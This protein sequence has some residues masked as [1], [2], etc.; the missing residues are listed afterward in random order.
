VCLSGKE[1]REEEKGASSV[2]FDRRNDQKKEENQFHLGKGKM[3]GWKSTQK[4]VSTT[5]RAPQKEK[6][7]RKGRGGGELLGHP[8]GDPENGKARR[9]EKRRLV[10]S[11]RNEGGGNLQEG[12]LGREIAN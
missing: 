8:S 4:I 7:A 6:K 1:R 10:G 9:L 11:E 3:T 12:A 2:E 5:A